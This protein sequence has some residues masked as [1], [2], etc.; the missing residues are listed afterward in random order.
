[1]VALPV[2][3]RLEVANFALFPGDPVGTGLTHAIEQ[4]VTLVAGI[5]GLGKTTLLNVILRLLTGPYDLT[6]AGLGQLGTT[7][8]EKPARLTPQTIRFFSQRVSDN[9]KDATALIDVRFGE[10]RLRIKRSLQTLQLLEASVDDRSILAQ[11]ADGDARERTYHDTIGGLMALSSFVDVL[12]VFHYVVFFPENRSGAL[13]D[14]NAQRQLLRALFVPGPAAAAISEA[15]RQVASADSY[16]RNIS[17]VLFQ[18]RRRLDQ[19]REAQAAAP[20]VRARLRSQQALL[21]A[22]FQRRSSLDERRETVEA[23][24]DAARLDFERAKIERED[25]ERAVERLKFEALDRMFPKLPDAAR[26]TILNLLSKSDCLVCG[27]HAET[28][29]AALESELNEGT[30]P[31]CHSPPGE[32]DN[33]VPVH[34]V[35]TSRLVRARERAQLAA[36]EAA[37]REEDYVRLSAEYDEILL[38]LKA[39]STEVSE[40]QGAVK[41]LGAL[42]PTPSQEVQSLQDQVTGLERSLTAANGRRAETA[43]ELRKALEPVQEAAEQKSDVLV[44]AFEKHASALLA[45]EATLVRDVADAG[46]A[47]QQAKFVVPAFFAE[48]T[49]AARPGLTRRRSVNDV[50]ESQRELIDL[51]FRFALLEAAGQAGAS[52]LVMETPEASLDEVAMER[53]GAALH[54]FADEGSN[55]LVA[56]SNLTNAGMIAR[57]FGGAASDPEVLSERR[58]RTIDLLRVSAKNRALELDT[59]G[60]YPQMLQRALMG[61]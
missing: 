55:R 10:S 7:L 34:K 33:V 19:A 47:Q 45:D 13:W 18:E 51:A 32:Q 15:E 30:C 6:G 16:A 56:T 2:L 4:G 25:A 41:K 35:E 26:L 21:D 48:M 23:E 17:S 11:T 52:T 49:A 60:R 14:I 38:A 43:V 9:A 36:E 40:L 12:L 28:A 44:R 42:L 37:S 53:V 61:S 22:S 20:G 24:R 59:A 31:V 27:A 5:N 50:S 58:R 3:T 39:I 57:L 54:A 46:I 8:P 1:M 29:R